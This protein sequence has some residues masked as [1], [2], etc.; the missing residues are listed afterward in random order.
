MHY[1]ISGFMY[2]LFPLTTKLEFNSTNVVMSNNY[3]PKSVRHKQ[4]WLYLSNWILY[5]IALTMLIDLN[6]NQTQCRS[7]TCYTEHCVQSGDRIPKRLVIVFP[8]QLF[9]QCVHL[10]CSVTRIFVVVIETVKSGEH[11]A[12]MYDT[13]APSLPISLDKKICKVN[14]LAW[15]VLSFR[16]M[17]D[18][19]ASFLQL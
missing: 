12:I 13:R 10:S 15:C 7:S 8:W 9:N 2:D 1:K 5:I 3:W 19:T 16:I 17:F 14:V 18:F 11:M 6:L 4:V